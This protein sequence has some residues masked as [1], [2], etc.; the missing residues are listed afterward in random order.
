MGDFWGHFFIFS[1]RRGISI[2]ILGT[3]NGPAILKNGQKTV[4][5]QQVFGAR[6]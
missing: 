3:R 5:R 2:L 1:I 6:K 4:L